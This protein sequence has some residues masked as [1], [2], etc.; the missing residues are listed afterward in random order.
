MVAL[1][2]VNGDRADWQDRGETL[3]A[4]VAPDDDSQLPRASLMPSM[5]DAWAAA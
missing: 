5:A 2:Y 4:D 3:Q 1:A